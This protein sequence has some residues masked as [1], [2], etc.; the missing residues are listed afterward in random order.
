MY[1]YDSLEEEEEEVYEDDFESMSEEED[2][3][4]RAIEI[5]RGA[6]ELVGQ[7][8]DMCA[9]EEENSEL[10]ASQRSLKNVPSSIFGL[11]APE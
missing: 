3:V 8:L 9:I 2:E 7:D 1:E 4:C 6:I 5:Y 11:T 10:E